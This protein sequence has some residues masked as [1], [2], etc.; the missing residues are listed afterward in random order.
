[1]QPRMPQ[2][3]HIC[4]NEISLAIASGIAAILTPANVTIAHLTLSIFF[5]KAD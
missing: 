3:K 5:E 2:M 4:A 1:M